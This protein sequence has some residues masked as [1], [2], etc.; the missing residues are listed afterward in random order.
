[1]GVV[2]EDLAEKFFPEGYSK[3]PTTSVVTRVE[4]EEKER[5]NE[6]IKA[7]MSPETV[8]DHD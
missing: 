5:N 6:F 2:D 3:T 7:A 1:M 8:K 4:F